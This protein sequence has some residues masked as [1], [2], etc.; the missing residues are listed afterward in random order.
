MRVKCANC[1]MIYEISQAPWDYPN[2]LL[3]TLCGLCHGG[4][5]KKLVIPGMKRIGEI[6]PEVLRNLSLR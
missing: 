2:S 6:L 5:H 3:I 1:G 4:H